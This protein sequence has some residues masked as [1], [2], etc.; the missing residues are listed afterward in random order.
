MIF[1]LSFFS[2]LKRLSKG[3]LEQVDQERLFKSEK[4]DSKKHILLFD[5]ALYR[6]RSLSPGL[7]RFAD[8]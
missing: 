8:F 3:I 4:K 6:I 5:N 1:S 7:R 2:L